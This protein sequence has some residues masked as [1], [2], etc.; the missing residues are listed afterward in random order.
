GC[1]GV[2]DETYI[3]VTVLKSD[4]SRYQIRKSRI[5][6]IVV[7]KCLISCNEWIQG[8]RAPQNHPGLFNKKYSSAR[9]VSER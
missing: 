1:L 9:N 6:T 7:G 3:D 5:S 8:H 4:K 2:L